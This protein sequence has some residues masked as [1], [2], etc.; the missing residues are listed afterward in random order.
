MCMYGD[1]DGWKVFHQADR[2]AAKQHRCG[3]CGRD[4][5]KGE[6]YR[7]ASGLINGQTLWD[8]F[9]TCAHCVQAIRWLQVACEGYMFEMAKEDLREHVDGYES[10]LR[11]AA[12]TRL[13]RWQAARWRNR[14]GALRPVEDVTVVVDRAIASY[15][16][17][18]DK[19]V[20][21]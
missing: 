8:T 1:G 14:A 17:Q 6:T 16:A 5:E 11:S 2:R 7:H 3:E 12:L 19:A 13:V 9:R 10:E 4:I 15:R 20:D 21:A 18:F